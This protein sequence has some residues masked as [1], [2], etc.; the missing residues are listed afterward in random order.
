MSDKGGSLPLSSISSAPLALMSDRG[1]DRYLW[2]PGFESRRPSMVAKK[3]VAALSRLGLEID[4][5]V[6]KTRTVIRSSEENSVFYEDVQ[7]EL[8]LRFPKF[9]FF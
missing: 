8:K 7:V 5:K 3:V 9:P 6:Q 1:G 2:V 4:I